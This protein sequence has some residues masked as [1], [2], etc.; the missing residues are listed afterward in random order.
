MARLRLGGARTAIE[1]LYSP[2]RRI[3]VFTC[4]RPIFAPWRAQQ[5]S[6]RTRTGEGK[7]SR[8]SRSRRCMISRS[9]EDTGR[10]RSYTLPRLTFRISACLTMDNRAH[11]RSSLCAQPSRL[12]R[13]PALKS[14]SSVSSPD[15]GVQR[16]H[17][18]HRRGRRPASRSESRRRF[19]AAIS[20]SFMLV[21][22]NVEMLGQLGYGSVALDGGQ[23]HLR[24][25]SRWSGSGE[26]V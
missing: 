7:L 14:F 3:S 21:G 24:L 8:C 17:I 23:S 26:V 25:E 22:V 13:A 16:F 11:G 15:L 4:R 10:G 2:I 18:D 5:A 19:R 12:G 6:R 1:R 20:I 9:A